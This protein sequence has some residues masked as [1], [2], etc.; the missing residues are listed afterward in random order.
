MEACEILFGAD[1]E[2]RFE[3]Y[4]REHPVVNGIAKDPAAGVIDADDAANGVALDESSQN[5]KVEGG[6]E[7]LNW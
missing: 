2:M 4:F 3:E 7:T 6:F 5:K 1:A